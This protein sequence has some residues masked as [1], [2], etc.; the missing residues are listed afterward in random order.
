MKK[1]NILTVVFL[2][3]T[4]LFFTEKANAQDNTGTEFWFT[5]F[6]E[7]YIDHLPGV[8]VVGYYDA[9]VTIDYIAR[10][11][12]NDAA[13]DPNCTKYTFNLIGGVPQYVQIPYDGQALCWRYADDLD[14]PEVAAPN[15]I[16]IT[17]TAPVAVYSQHF[18]AASSEMTPI[19]PITAMGMDYILTAYRENDQRGFNARATITAIENNTTI[20]ITLPSNTWTSMTGA[21]GAIKRAPGSTFT[22]TLNKG[23]TYTMLSNDAGLGA[24]ATPA[25]ATVTVGNNQGL[26]GMRIT[27]DKIISVM[28]GTDCTWVGNDEYPGC[29]A[30]DLTCTH[31]RP[32]NLWSNRYI[33]TQTLVRPNQTSLAV[34]LAANVPN[35]EPYPANY[36]QLSVSDYMLIT[37]K[38]NGTTVTISGQAAYTKTLN[39]GQWFIYESPGNSNPATP[40]PTTNPG[41]SHHL[42]TS[43]NPIQVI[44]MMKGWQC[45]NNNPADPTQMLVMEESL[46]DDNYIITNP[47]QYINNF[48][49]FIIKEPSASAIARSTLNLNVAGA[50]VPIPTGAAPLGDG[51]GGWTKIGGTPYYFQR[52]NVAA[53]GAIKAKSV[54]GAN[55]VRYPFAFYASG[56]TNASSYGY[57]GGATCNLEVYPDANPDPVCLG[58]PVTFSLDSVKNGGRIAGVKLYNYTWNIYQGTTLLNTYSGLDS[59]GSYTYT[60]TVTGNLYAVIRL[61]DNAGCDDIDTVYFTVTSPPA[62]TDQPDYAICGSGNFQL[63]TGTNLTGNQAYYSGA[64]GTGTTYLP[65][66]NIPA[67]GTYYMYDSY[68]PTCF[69]EQSVAITIN[70]SPVVDPTTITKNCDGTGTA[71]N[72]VFTVSGGNGGPYTVTEIAPGGIGG[73]FTGNT[74]TSNSIASGVTHNFEITDGNG[75]PPAVVSGIKN[76]ACFSDAGSMNTTPINTCGNGNLSGVAGTLAPGPDADDAVSY[77]LHTSSG[78][79]LGTIVATST[80]LS[81]PFNA[82]TMTYGTTYYIS[83]VVGNDNGSGEADL[84]DGCL[85]VAPGTPVTWKEAV[86]ATLTGIT[87]V[88]EG[89]SSTLTFNITGPSPFNLVY[90]NGTNNTNLVNTGATANEVVNPTGTTNYTLVSAVSNTNGCTATVG[91]ANQTI[92]IVVNT[93]PIAVNTTESCDNTNT[94]YTVSFDIQQGSAP[95]TVDVNSPMGLV[96]TFSGSTWTSDPMPSGTAYDFSLYDGNTCGIT[97]ISGMRTCVCTSSAGGMNTTPQAICGTGPITAAQDPGQPSY[98]DGN[99]ITSFIL[100]T[101]NDN[102]VGTL[103]DQDP[104]PTFG[105]LAG[106]M[107][108]G[109]VYYISA[110]VGNDDGTGNVDL[111]DPC[112][113]IAYGTPVVWNEQPAATSSSN[114]P[115]CANQLLQLTSSTSNNMTGVTYTWTGPNGFFSNQQNPTIPAAQ[116]GAS[117]NYVVTIAKVGCSDQST[118]AVVVNPEAV[119]DFTTSL[120][121]PTNVAH[122]FDFTNNSTNGNT[123]LWDFGDG[124]TSTDT[125]PSHQYTAETGTA[126]VTLIAYNVNGCNDTVQYSVDLTV[127][128]EEEEALLYVPNSFT[129]DGNEINQYF[130]PVFNASVDLQ[131]FEMRIFNR[132]GQLVFESNDPHTGWDGT[133]EAKLSETGF[134]TWTISFRD[135]YTSERYRYNGHVNLMR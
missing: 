27:A 26:N 76:C 125:D 63:I 6:S 19:L 51:S 4:S 128:T 2:L 8:Y 36:N 33:T 102:T 38:T 74:W 7:T 53:A 69:S 42:I 25:G 17:S 72:V 59:I 83:R 45:D 20:N 81:F 111:N 91:G 77:V 93:Q 21:N 67:S 9:T 64:G 129:P 58:N 104:N 3:F 108:Y 44:Q 117:G 86:T 32:T 98:L 122:A 101:T 28:G 54:A 134:Y 124:S 1:F 97:T 18:G 57:M 113:S 22:I 46:W 89:N 80:G 87:P 13:G 106:S 24:G 78:G 94:S 116:V 126:L 109:T 133:Y 103:L 35:I 100:H 132:W 23:Q 49:V 82:G 127:T 68:S 31:L 131:N 85:D 30:C 115:I 41:A 105:F 130:G 84:T 75:C 96:G 47:S 48:F 107:T 40:P 62:I 112:V 99:D 119:A 50:N 92:Q 61:T 55:G 114:G 34:G 39:A 5:I 123:Y 70:T 15:G 79:I 120:T 43:N 56:S 11:P 95:Y 118:V 12:A 71:Y 90:S 73:S 14:F 52:I 10:N 135:K 110:V 37:A 65:G 29:G 121:T 66:S 16:R 88:C 60:P